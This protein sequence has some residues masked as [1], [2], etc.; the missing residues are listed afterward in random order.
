MV[1]GA[2][3]VMEVAVAGG[4]HLDP[5]LPTDEWKIIDQVLSFLAQYNGSP[6]GRDAEEV[7]SYIDALRRAISIIQGRP[8]LAALAEEERRN[9]AAQAQAALHEWRRRSQELEHVRGENKVL[10]AELLRGRQAL[11]EV[12][13]KQAELQRSVKALCA[14]I[15]LRKKPISR[16]PLLRRLQV[17]V[18]HTLGTVAGYLGGLSPASSPTFPCQSI[19]ANLLFSRLLSFPVNVRKESRRKIVEHFMLAP[20]LLSCNSRCLQ[21]GDVVTFVRGE[22]ASVHFVEVVDAHWTEDITSAVRTVEIDMRHLAVMHRTLGGRKTMHTDAAV[23]LL[24][25]DLFPSSDCVVLGLSCCLRLAGQDIRRV[26]M[27][28]RGPF[29]NGSECFADVHDTRQKS[30]DRLSTAGGEAVEVPPASCEKD[31]RVALTRCR[32]QLFEQAQFHSLSSFR[33]QPGSMGKEEAD[34]LLDMDE[35]SSDEEK[36]RNTVYKGHFLICTHT[37]THAHMHTCIHAYMHTCVHACIHTYIHTCTYIPTY[38]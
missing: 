28:F 4:T 8:E 30:G 12:L 16:Y 17:L 5:D 34:E 7:M 29:P 11:A 38:R 36:P 14:D 37:Y 27:L 1:S 31:L 10:Q 21:N 9:L 2:A 35:T 20:D 26:E 19:P 24:M 32:P 22:L 23:D 13:N 3:D 6:D 15:E 18:L 25:S 33:S